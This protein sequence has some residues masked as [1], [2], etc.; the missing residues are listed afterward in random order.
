[1]ISVFSA[2]ITEK[3]GV[4]CKKEYNMWFG[5]KE[6]PICGVTCYFLLSLS[7]VKQTREMFSPN[8]SEP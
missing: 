1:M 8:T 7:P 6:S 2:T 3:C 5:A 4:W